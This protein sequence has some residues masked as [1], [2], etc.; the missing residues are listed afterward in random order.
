MDVKKARRAATMG[1]VLESTAATVLSGVILWW[2][3]SP[4]SRSIAQ[5][6]PAAAP[7]ETLELKTAPPL[8]AAIEPSSPPPPAR[9]M[10]EAP[11]PRPEAAALP[12]APIAAS[13]VATRPPTTRATVAEPK[14]SPLPEFSPF[15][16][17]LLFENFS[18]YKEGDTTDW[19][20]NV[21]VKLG[22]D[23]RKWLVSY[24]DGA[25]AVGR[26]IRLPNNFYL[27]CRYSAYIPEATRGLSGF[28]K[29]PVAS[30]IS[31]LGDGGARYDIDW[32]IGCG[33]EKLRL[34]PLEPP[35]ANKYYHTIRLPGAAASEVEV[36]Q[37][38]GT[39]RITRAKNVINVLLN[40]QLAAAGMLSP[41]GPLAGFEIQVV[42]AKSG[43][44]SLTEFKIAR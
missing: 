22:L 36:G 14:G 43:T 2:V 15:E 28:W 9:E 27:E 18:Q 33:S 12:M 25:H 26:K 40:G 39:L 11:A 24:I 13:T 7:V 30:R 29:D 42:K 44:L 17:I 35:P 10:K 3:T 19:G 4:M 20:Q 1:R 37:P 41:A 38:T 31:L 6:S 5:S 34:N 8:P 21:S 32:V 16:S 23:R